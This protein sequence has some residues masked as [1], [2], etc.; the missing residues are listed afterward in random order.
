MLSWD[1]LS[2][3]MNC[4]PVVC[5]RSPSAAASAEQNVYHT[6][7][8][9]FEYDFKNCRMQLLVYFS[10][11]GLKGR[12]PKTRINR[13]NGAQSDKLFRIIYLWFKFIIC[14]G[15]FCNGAFEINMK[16]MNFYALWWSFGDSGMLALLC[17]PVKR[18]GLKWLGESLNQLVYLSLSECSPI[19]PFSQTS[20]Q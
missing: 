15:A 13:N 6:M 9:I 17:L 16:R 19:H 4:H 10:V 14:G 12:Y 18:S 1:S 11:G 2:F 20:W 3:C 7:A 5:H 8:N